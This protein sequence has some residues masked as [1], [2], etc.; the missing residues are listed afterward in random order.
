LGARA[1]P[2]PS[3]PLLAPGVTEGGG[4]DSRLPRIGPPLG[5][6]VRRMVDVEIIQQPGFNVCW[7]TKVPTFQNTLGQDAQPS[8]DLIE[9]RA[10]KGRQVQ[11]MLMRGIAQDGSA[12]DT[13][14]PWALK[15]RGITPRSP[16]ATDLEAPVRLEMIDPPL[17]PWHERQLVHDMG[18]MRREIRAG[19]CDAEMP[20][21]LPCGH[22][23][24]R[25]QGSR[26]MA[27]VLVLPFL[28]L[29]WRRG[30]RGVFPW[31]HLH[32]GLFLRADHH[33]PMRR[34]AQGID[35]QRTHVPRFRATR[36]GMAMEPIDTAR[37]FEI[38]SVQHPPEARAAH[39]P[40]TM[41][42]TQASPQVVETPARGSTGRVS[43]LGSSRRQDIA[44]VR[45]GEKRR[46]RPDRGASWSPTRPCARER[47]RH[48][49]TV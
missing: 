19:A 14:T 9:P 8:R 5:M 31:Q 6:G 27:D 11:P 1:K 3:L 45:G 29:P 18:Q 20:P 35:V 13:P 4:A 39:A 33:T 21:H 30:E 34:E 46:G 40:A 36:G 12:F 28:R 48:R 49:H 41:L 15:A 32:A 23:K 7:G 37:R 22:H 42:L 16:Q 2:G 47:L 44:L 25:E 26:P 24:G 43:G 17:V 38:R 10:M